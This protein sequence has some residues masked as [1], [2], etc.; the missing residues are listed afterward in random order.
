MP[1][2]DP[3]RSLRHGAEGAITGYG[4]HRARNASIFLT[5]SQIVLRHVLDGSRIG[6]ARELDAVLGG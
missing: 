1:S 4:G 6:T 5:R 2:D 3:S